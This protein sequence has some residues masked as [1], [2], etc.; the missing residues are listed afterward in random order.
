MKD[1]L[2][3][4]TNLGTLVTLGEI[5]SFQTKKEFNVVNYFLKLIEES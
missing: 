3:R 1:W 5:V 2:K 4:W